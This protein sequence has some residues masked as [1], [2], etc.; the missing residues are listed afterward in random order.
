MGNTDGT[1]SIPAMRGDCD[2]AAAEVAPNRADCNCTWG[3]TI[4]AY[5]LDFPILH[6]KYLLILT[7]NPMYKISNFQCIFYNIII[8]SS[9]LG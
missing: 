2:V 6:S 9:S 4:G 3:G 1:L 8:L 7:V 5:T